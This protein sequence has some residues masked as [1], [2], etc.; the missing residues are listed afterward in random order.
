MVRRSARVDVGEKLGVTTLRDY[1]ILFASSRVGLRQQHD[2]CR[3]WSLRGLA[4]QVRYATSPYNGASII[5]LWLT[6]SEI[7]IGKTRPRSLLARLGGAKSFGIPTNTLRLHAYAVAATL[8]D[9][10]LTAIALHLAKAITGAGGRILIVDMVKDARR[11]GG[12]LYGEFKRNFPAMEVWSPVADFAYLKTL[13]NGELTT[14][15]AYLA[16]APDVAASPDS[17]RPSSVALAEAVSQIIGGAVENIDT[18]AH[19]GAK[20]RAPYLVVVRGGSLPAQT[21]SMMRGLG[22][23]VLHLT[24]LWSHDAVARANCLTSIR[25]APRS[26][27]TV[28]AKDHA[29]MG[30]EAVVEIGNPLSP[31]TIERISIDSSVLS[32]PQEE[33]RISLGSLV[34]E[35]IFSSLRRRSP[36]ALPWAAMRRNLRLEVPSTGEAPT[37]AMTIGLARQVLAA[38]G[39]VI[40]IDPLAVQQGMIEPFAAQL[41]H[42]FPNVHWVDDE[43]GLDVVVRLATGLAQSAGE[44]IAIVTGDACTPV[45]RQEGEYGAIAHRPVL[46]TM[47]M[48]L[49]AQL[50]VCEGEADACDLPA[51][52]VVLRNV[53]MDHR[54]VAHLGELANGNMAI[55]H[56]DSG[57]LRDDSALFCGT[58]VSSFSEAG[59]G[60]ARAFRAVVRTAGGAAALPI[61]FEANVASRA[62]I[63]EALA[64]APPARESVQI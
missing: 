19:Y 62:Q 20:A 53:Q 36:L 60:G 8:G 43:A 16:P 21:Y 11:D 45:V 34:D 25:I 1:F 48:A 2:A 6:M 32:P 29:T 41:L 31:H 28:A 3:V 44:S 54:T 4:C 17:V 35:G 37:T 7:E 23:I 26:T 27:S 30:F 18:E 55:V 49:F 10:G 14:Q 59:D 58:H 51:V 56:L 52:L 50:L 33:L 61:E 57:R 40:V 15:V 12:R 63:E 39:R 22:I 9:D 47:H 42:A 24:D 13:L 64:N 5:Q 46:E 38:G